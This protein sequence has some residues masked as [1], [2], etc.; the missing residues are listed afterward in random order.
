MTNRIIEIVSGEA[1][2]DPRLRL[3]CDDGIEQMVDFRSLLSPAVHP[4]IRAYLDPERFAAFRV[5]YG[6]LVWGDH[7]LCSPVIDLYRSRLERS[8]VLEAAA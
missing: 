2:G 3:R 4:D 8:G 1:A 6:D 7:D 5:E